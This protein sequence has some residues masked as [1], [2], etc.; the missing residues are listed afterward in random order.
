MGTFCSLILLIITFIYAYQ[1][2]GVF[3]G[4]KDISIM[5][6]SEDMY[7]NDADL[8]THKMGLNIAVAFSAYDSEEEWVLDPAYGSLHLNHRSWGE[9]PDGT[10]FVNRLA[11]KGHN[12]T[13]ENL[14][15]EGDPKNF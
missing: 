12:C 6:S 4:K 2:L 8:F 9:N 3:L 11:L 1:K 5:Y 13:R 10:Y 14:A 15:L 7:F